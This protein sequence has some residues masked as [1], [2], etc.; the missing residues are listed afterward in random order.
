MMYLPVRLGPALV[1]GHLE[2]VERQ[3][4]A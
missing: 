2:G 1:D 3:V 4:G